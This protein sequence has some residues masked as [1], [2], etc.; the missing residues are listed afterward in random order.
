MLSGQ[1]SIVF[2]G[3]VS[4]P[5]RQLSDRQY[6]V[7]MMAIQIFSADTNHANRQEKA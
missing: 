1:L 2:D 6:R 5:A 7:I 3:R 4:P